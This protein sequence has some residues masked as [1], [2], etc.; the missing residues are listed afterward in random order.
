MNDSFPK[1]VVIGELIQP[2]FQWNP[3]NSL[4]I[5]SKCINL[6]FEQ[7]TFIVKIV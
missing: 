1:M 5:Q 4:K 7:S 6:V 2:K 3:W